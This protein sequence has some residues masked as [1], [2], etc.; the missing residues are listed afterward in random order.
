MSKETTPPFR[1]TEQEKNSQLWGRLKEHLERLNDRD[2]IR[3]D[4][5]AL[6]EQETLALRC[7][8]KARKELINLDF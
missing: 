5:T 7:K 2:R 1:M 4:D 8:I 6:T 3:N